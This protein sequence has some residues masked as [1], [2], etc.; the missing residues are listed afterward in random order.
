MGKENTMKKIIWIAV[1]ILMEISVYYSSLSNPIVIEVFSEFAF[2]PDGWVLEIVSPFS[3]NTDGWYLVT[4]QDT[5]YLKPIEIWG[6]T[7]YLITQDSLLEPLV[8]DSSGDN[9]ELYDSGGYL[10]G[11]LNFGTSLDAQIA[12]PKIGQ[13]ISKIYDRYCLDNT[14]SLGQPNDIENVHGYVVGWVKDDEDVPLP[15]VKVAYQKCKYVYNPPIE[16]GWSWYYDTTLTNSDGFFTISSLT[17]KQYISFNMQNYNRQSYF[18][19]VFPESTVTMNITMSPVVSVE[20]TESQVVP[21]DFS[22][23]D[24]FPNPFN[25]EMQIQYSIPRS[26]N[27]SIEVFDIG[28]KLVDKIFSG[29]QSAG[30]YQ[31]RW[32]AAHFPSSV[33]IIRIQA[34]E[35][36]LSKKCALVK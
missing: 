16:E 19:Q 25:P 34:G 35:I 5:A 32:N 11:Y 22:I 2:T 21:K 30:K 26:S 8:I 13:S 18:V 1:F 17:I 9:L 3:Y 4:K 33:Y 15:N 31:A 6:D 23:S 27:V 12:A 28:G 10:M 20:R 14:P 24:P 7:L 29:F 36:V